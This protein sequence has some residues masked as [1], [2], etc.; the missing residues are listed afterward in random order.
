MRRWKVGS[1]AACLA[2]MLALTACGSNSESES[3]GSEAKKSSEP[4]TIGLLVGMTGGAS[5]VGVPFSRGAEMA[6]E[7]LNAAGGVDGRKVELEVADN[8]TQ[9]VAGVQAALKLAGSNDLDTL[10]CSCFSTIFFP[11]TKALAKYDLVLTND[12]ASSP[13]VRSL[14]GTIITTIPTDD[15][16]GAELARFAYGLGYKEAALVSPN[17][18]YGVTYRAAVK[19]AY[20]E[21]GGKLTLDLVVD[22]GLPNYRPE[23]Q[24]VKD[25]GSEAVMA[26]TYSDDARLQF[27][28]LLETGWNGV[29]FKLYPSV[30]RFNEDKGTEGHLLGLE[31]DWLVGAETKKWRDAYKA[32]YNEDP[33]I[34]AAVGYDAVMLN[35]RGVAGATSKKSE[36]IRAAMV[37]A[38]EDYSGPTGQLKFD[39][40]FVRVDMPLAYYAVKDGK[41]VRVDE[42]AKPLDDAD[43]GGA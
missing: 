28:Q 40:D 30:T 9:P 34:W 43:G 42:H 13:E 22:N 5:T 15:V 39:E 32:K 20:Q 26:G 29:A 33:V 16:L 14:P 2:M 25:T 7:E 18:P 21:A 12:A 38:A 17:D 24:R 10:I 36:D 41:Y 11:L 37:K 27:K 3:G 4:I 35:A 23:M 19:K 31:S 8:K 6:A 1:V